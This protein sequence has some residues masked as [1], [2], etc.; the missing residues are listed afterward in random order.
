MYGFIYVTTCKVNGKKY[1]GQKKYVRGWKDYIGSGKAFRN[2]VE[3]YGKECFMREIICEAETAEELNELEYNFSV[4]FN[5]VESDEW[6]NLCYGGGATSGYKHSEESRR[7]MSQWQIGRKFSEETKQL[8]S[9]K[10]KGRFA[11]EKNPMYGVHRKLT[12]EHKRKISEN[13]KNQNG[14]LNW[15]Y[16]KTYGQ[17]PRARAVFCVEL[18][19]VFDSAKRAAH[20]LNINY[21]SIISVCKGKRNAAGG[22]HFKYADSE[23][24]TQIA[25]GCVAL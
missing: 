17:N 2:A 12:E 18:N 4:M 6:Y 15:M 23:I 11:G 22:Y 5:V 9:E 19:Q 25:E 13:H 20:E 8:M 7:K 16:G 24:T 10:A 14:E 1:L 3:K 21:S